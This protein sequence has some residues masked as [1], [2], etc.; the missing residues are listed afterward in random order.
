MYNHLSYEIKWHCLVNFLRHLAL[1]ADLKMSP[2]TLNVNLCR[3][4]LQKCQRRMLRYKQWDRRYCE[5]LIRLRFKKN[6]TCN[7]SWKLSGNEFVKNLTSLS[8]K[9]PHSSHL[10]FKTESKTSYQYNSHSYQMPFILHYS[11]PS[12]KKLNTKSK[13]HAS[14]FLNLTKVMV[15][16]DISCRL[17]KWLH[18]TTAFRTI[19]KTNNSFIKLFDIWSRQSALTLSLVETAELTSECKWSRNLKQISVLTGIR[20]PDWQS[21][22]TTT[23]HR[24]L[25]IK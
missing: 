13:I 21:S 15:F 11:H 24:E 18:F 10:I 3:Q 25:C 19:K 20:N 4:Q 17:L 23:R 9:F 12:F 22:R 16:I 1:T 2:S 14:R 6:Y 5:D 8:L 7:S